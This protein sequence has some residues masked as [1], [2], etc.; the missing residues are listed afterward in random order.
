MKSKGSHICISL[1]H[2]GLCRFHLHHRRTAPTS[3][4]AINQHKYCQYQN[5]NQFVYFERRLLEIYT[6]LFRYKFH[7]NSDEK[8]WILLSYWKCRNNNL[9]IQRKKF[10]GCDGRRMPITSIYL[11]ILFLLTDGIKES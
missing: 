8:L 10:T 3:N 9:S 4:V 1:I 2:I 6:F 7:G 5:I 11:F